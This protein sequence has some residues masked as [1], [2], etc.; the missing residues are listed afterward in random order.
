[1]QI[2]DSSIRPAPVP[3]PLPRPS[4]P[5][6]VLLLEPLPLGFHE[7]LSARGIV[8]PVPPS[9]VARDSVGRPLRDEAG[10]VVLQVDAADA[11][12]RQAREQYHQRV[13]V[14]MLYQAV[15][16]DEAITFDTSPPAETSATAD[17][18]PRFADDL[19]AEL[20]QAGLTAGD[21]ILLCQEICR[22]SN[23]L[24]DHLRQAHQSFFSPPQAAAPG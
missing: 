18:W 13:A 6:L 16:H 24:D 17:E 19:Y 3:F 21:L 15:Q 2:R 1:M 22:L 14:L 11:A 8:P 20:Q 9:R 5:P 10:Q 4:G 7:Q 23:L 12:F